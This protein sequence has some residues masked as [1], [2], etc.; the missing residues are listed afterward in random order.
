MEGSSMTSRNLSALALATLVCL[1]AAAQITGTA[2]GLEYIADTRYHTT[3]GNTPATANSLYNLL[4]RPEFGGAYSGVAGLNLNTSDGGFRCSGALISS[5]HVLTAAHCVTDQ[6]TAQLNFL[7]GQAFFATN[8]TGPYTGTTV[9]VNIASVTVHPGWTFDYLTG[10]NDLAVLTLAT[11]APVGAKIYDLYT[12]T[13]E[14]GKDS[15]KV[16]WGTV[17]LSSG[18][19]Y[20][21]FGFRKGTN[22][23][24]ATAS[25]MM[26]ALYGETID[27][28]LQYDFDNGTA[29]F[30]AFDTFF[31]IADLGTGLSEVMSAGGDSGGPT[32]I[33]GKIAG[34]TSYGITLRFNDGTSSDAAI[35]LNSS[36]GEFGGD[37]RVSSHTQWITTQ[38]PEPGTY[39]LMLVGLA[40]VASAARRRQR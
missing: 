28:V 6:A 1:P 3:L 39:A 10:G 24:D 12:S 17:G 22:V 4:H 30:D 33:D 23:Y 5:F 36:Y 16:G 38:I 14:I 11:A 18:F 7:S 21:F 37:T 25:T 26:Q 31:G 40:A 8:K 9:A 32:F 13:D 19:D 34:I 29:Q 20:G 27:S 15:V 2:S 35:G